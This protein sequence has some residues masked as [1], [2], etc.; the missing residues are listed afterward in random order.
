MA[1][2]AHKNFAYSTIATAPSPTTSGTSL[3]VQSGDGAKFPLIPFNA[4]VWPVG[5]KPTTANAE[6]IRVTGISTD[7]FSTIVRAQ[8]SSSARSIQVGDQIAAAITAKTLTDVEIPGT[9]AS[10]GYVATLETTASSSYGDLATSGPS[11]TVTI[12]PSGKALLIFG[13]EMSNSIIADYADMSVVVSGANTI[14]VGTEPY[15]L[16]SM[17][18]LDDKSIYSTLLTGL[19]AGSTTFKCQYRVISGGT[20]SFQKREISVIPY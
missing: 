15:R 5:A 4:V 8:E 12:G 18:A 16:F 9:Q 11:V 13:A 20:A 1:Y 6:I 2:D 14:S 3:V 17:G 10:N 7:T 19:T